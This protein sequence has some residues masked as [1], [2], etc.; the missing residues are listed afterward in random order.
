M[1][2]NTFFIAALSVIE[3][4]IL[5]IGLYYNWEPEISIG[6]TLSVPFLLLFALCKST[7][8]SYLNNPELVQASEYCYVSELDMNEFGNDIGFEYCIICNMTSGNYGNR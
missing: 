8:H 7:D 1:N 2:P 3:I 6:V 4:L 5:V